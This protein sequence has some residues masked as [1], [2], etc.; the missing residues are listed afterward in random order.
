MW[1]GIQSVP[2]GLD[3][4][5]SS[6]VMDSLHKAAVMLA[7]RSPVYMTGCGT[8][9][10]SAIAATHVFHAIPHYPAYACNAFEF[11]AYPPPGLQDSAVIGI[12]HTGGTPAVIQSVELARSQGAF[13]LGF[14][15][16]V[17][18]ALARTASHVVSSSLG[19]EPALPKTRSYVAALLRGYLLALELSRLRKIDVSQYEPFLQRSPQISRNLLDS[20]EGQVKEIAQN[21]VVPRRIVVAGGG[22]QLATALE[23]SLKLTEAALVISVAWELEEA[24]HGTW[25]STQPED[26]VIIL[27]IKGP[28]FAK[29]QRLAAGMHMISAKVWVITNH[30][31]EIPDADFITRLPSDIP[32]FFMP[33][34]AILPLYQYTYFL[35][36]AQGVHPDNMRLADPRYL[37]AR[38]LMRDTIK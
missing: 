28:G 16:V 15:D 25:A 17:G 1:E 8:S 13:T 5:L 31:G 29:C 3:D 22:P 7:N 12:S 37:Q 10:F 23:A 18:S 21:Q 9:Y 36:L 30:E 26:L 38:M 6:Q 19:V 14:T 33:L 11:Y 27:A 32:E 34:F 4:I 24:V 2:L 35:A 20:V